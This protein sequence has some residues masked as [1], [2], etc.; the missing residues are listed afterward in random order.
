[1]GGRERM[2]KMKKPQQCPEGDDLTNKG[3]V[4]FHEEVQTK[5]MENIKCMLPVTTKKAHIT[6]PYG[7]TRAV[8]QTLAY[9]R[10]VY[11]YKVY[12]RYL[13]YHKVRDKAKRKIDDEK[14]NRMKEI[15]KA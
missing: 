14:D 5:W 10:C 8:M 1:M 13:L 3:I 15:G 9:W 6:Q 7:W 2:I 4:G 11:T 12:L